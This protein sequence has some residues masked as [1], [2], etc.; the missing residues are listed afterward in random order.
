MISTPERLRL[1]AD[2]YEQHPEAKP[3][4]LT[5]IHDYRFT[6][7]ELASVRRALGGRWD[8]RPEDAHFFFTQQIVPGVE[9]G[10]FSLRE[11]VCTRRVIGTETVLEPDPDAPMIEV[12]REIVEWD[13]AALDRTAHQRDDS[14]RPAM[15]GPPIARSHPTEGP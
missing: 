15:A 7:K 9:Y 10:L 13:C 8:K 2:W 4:D 5:R 6:A 3:P 12:V 11:A 14:G 1:L